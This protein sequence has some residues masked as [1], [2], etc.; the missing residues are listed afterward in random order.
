MKTN[1]IY[2]QLAKYNTK[3]GSF[4]CTYTI[5]M[6]ELTVKPMHRIVCF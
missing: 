3:K 2:P 5:G 1:T 4:I 6:E